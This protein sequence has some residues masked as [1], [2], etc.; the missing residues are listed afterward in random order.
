MGGATCACVCGLV[1]AV[2]LDFGNAPSDVHSL[3]IETTAQ[4]VT[5]AAM[6]TVV[7]TAIRYLNICRIA[8]RRQ[9]LAVAVIRD[10]NMRPGYADVADNAAVW[11]RPAGLNRIVVNRHG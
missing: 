3:R 8:V 4:P 7:T 11:E 2:L 6:A 1:F 9:S 5:A 10:T